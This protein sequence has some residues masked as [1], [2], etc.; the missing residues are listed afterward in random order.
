MK[1]RN[2]SLKRTIFLILAMIMV[3]G[4]CNT[5]GSYGIYDITRYG[6]RPDGTVQT[7]AIQKTIDECHEGGGG[8]VRIPPGEFI[9]GAIQLRSNVSLK[10][11]NGAILKGSLDTADY[12][13]NGI[14]HGMIYAQNERNISIQGQ[15]ILD[16]RGT[17]FMIDDKSHVSAD[18]GREY[19]RQ[20]ENFMPDDVVFEDGPVAYE[21]RPGMM[22]VILRSE[23]ISIREVTFKD[24]PE[25]TIRFGECDGVLVEGISIYNNLMVPNSDGIHCTASR[26]VR[27]SNCD[28]RAGDDAIIVT[29]FPNDIGVHGDQ[30]ARDKGLSKERLGNSSGYAENVTVSNC[31]L[32]SRSAGIRVGYGTVP[33]RNCVFENIVIY[34]SNRGIGVFARD[35]ADISNLL[36]TNIIIQTRL[37]SGH[38]WGNGEPVHVSAIPQNHDV[39]VGKISGIR[40]RNITARA[41][42]GVLIYAYEDGLV[43]NIHIENTDLAISPGKNAAGY[44]GNID[45]RPAFS[46]AY[47]IFKYD[48]PGML[49][50]NIRHV[51]IENFDLTWEGNI[52]GY[53]NHGIGI[54]GSS[55]VLIGEF[56]G[57]EPHQ[58]KENAAVSIIES[59]H[60]RIRNS[61]AKPGTGTFVLI[62]NDRGNHRIE[63]N[64]TENAQIKIRRY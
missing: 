43:E 10:L 32:Q 15:G 24:S 25:W 56:S 27:I 46:P 48:L 44:G 47:A 33:I 45:L 16:G 57:R 55:D 6:A 31:L 20:G 23:N 49:I 62:K 19:T 1:K 11:E 41:E 5:P 60:I 13:I 9:T 38:W 58:G 37:H 50:K 2:R 3:F 59:N 29:G 35:A 36:F 28:I 17:A 34:D 52:P 54:E 39:P 22:V 21:Y 8:T 7:R 30:E 53:H 26:N 42:T 40:F 4:Y 12:R 51:E 14:S 64:L 63:N 61:F 18:F